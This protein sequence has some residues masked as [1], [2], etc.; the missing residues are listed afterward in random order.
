MVHH[1][2]AV[3]GV[4]AATGLAA[5]HLGGNTIHTWA[6]IGTGE[7]AVLNLLKM[8]RRNKGAMNRWVSCKVLIIDESEFF[9]Q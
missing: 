2:S 4:T 1:P 8:V 9:N 7:E 5:F 6:G 3:V